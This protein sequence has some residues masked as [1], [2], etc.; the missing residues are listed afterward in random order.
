MSDRDCSSFLCT[1]FTLYRALLSALVLSR[2]TL[3]DLL[4]SFAVSVVACEDTI[5]ACFLVVRRVLELDTYL[6]HV[7]SVELYHVMT[8]Y[9]LNE[10][11]LT[12]MR[13][14]NIYTWYAWC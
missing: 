8:N 12:I 9:D 6:L 7:V 10:Y 2:S 4:L 13:V 11:Q 5:C 3:L 1:A 14:G